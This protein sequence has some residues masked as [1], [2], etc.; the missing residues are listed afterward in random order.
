MINCKLDGTLVVRHI[1]FQFD[2]GWELG[3]IKSK[4]DTSNSRRSKFNYDIFYDRMDGTVSTRL[5]CSSYGATD[6]YAPYV[7]A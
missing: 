6:G 5:D 7:G 1:A 3:T 2:A 4:L